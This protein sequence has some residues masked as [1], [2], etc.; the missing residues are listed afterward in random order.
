MV[1]WKTFHVSEWGC[2]RLAGMH[3]HQIHKPMDLSSLSHP[4]PA[5]YLGATAGPSS[6]KPGEDWRMG[7]NRFQEGN[8]KEH[9]LT[10]MQAPAIHPFT[11]WFLLFLLFMLCWLST[12]RRLGVKSSARVRPM[13]TQSNPVNISS[14]GMPH[15]Y[16]PQF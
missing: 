15:Q 1:P 7:L 10:F 4:V 9:L 6:G 2:N 16:Q 5:S 8:R 13:S 3:I 11:C 14:A 12:F